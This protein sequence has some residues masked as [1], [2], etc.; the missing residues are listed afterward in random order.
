MKPWVGPLWPEG[1][2]AEAKESCAAQLEAIRCKHQVGM[3]GQSPRFEFSDVS[4]KALEYERCVAQGF[5]PTRDL[6]HDWFNGLVWLAYP[7]TK[8]LINRLHVQ[9][10]TSLKPPSGNQRS[11]LRDAITLWDESGMIL[12]TNNPNVEPALDGHDWPYLFGQLRPEWG[13]H[14][15]PFCFGHGLL[16]ALRSPHKGLCAKVRVVQVDRDIIQGFGMV[17]G[18]GIRLS[19]CAVLDEIFLAVIHGLKSPRDLKP[20]PVMGIPGWF[21]QNESPGYY[22]DESVFRKKPTRHRRK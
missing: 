13:Y 10:D 15:L 16:D 1:F 19:A 22:D 9:E 14:I 11:P 12:L 21:D 20:L 7:K 4:M 8:A 2:D 17:P 3:T 18:V 6:Y 5:I